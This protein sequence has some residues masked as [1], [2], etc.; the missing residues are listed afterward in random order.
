MPTNIVI[1]GARRVMFGYAKHELK[2]Y[3]T[4][5]TTGNFRWDN[6]V[7][8]LE[9]VLKRHATIGASVDVLHHKEGYLG[10]VKKT[11]K[12]NVFF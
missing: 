11:K 12:Q 6:L 7:D 1:L 10:R 4:G 9:D 2:T 8:F 3:V 5:D